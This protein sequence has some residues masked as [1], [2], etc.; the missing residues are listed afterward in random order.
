MFTIHGVADY[1]RPA[2]TILNIDNY[3]NIE[4]SFNSTRHNITINR[5]SSQK[6]TMVTFNADG[7][8]LLPSNYTFRVCIELNSYVS[9]SYAERYNHNPNCTTKHFKYIQR[10]AGVYNYTEGDIVYKLSISIHSQFTSRSPLPVLP[11]DESVMIA[12]S[13]FGWQYYHILP[14]NHHHHSDGGSC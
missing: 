12:I 4:I 2:T 5:L 13:Q 8:A 3:Q 10:S 7:G 9:S 6:K 11:T 1:V 14:S